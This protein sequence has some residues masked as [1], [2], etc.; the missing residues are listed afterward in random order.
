[1]SRRCS[2]PL[3]LMAVIFWVGGC[4]LLGGQ[5]PAPAPTIGEL[6]TGRITVA[7]LPTVEIAPLML[8]IEEGW[9]ADAGLDVQVQTAG[10]GPAT[11]A[12]I[13]GGDYDIAYSSYV[14]FIAAQAR[15]VA[16]L[17]IVT[18]N[19]F[20][21]PNTA[22]LVTGPNSALTSVLQLEGRRIA[23][24][25]P[26]TSA[27]L[28]VK[29]AMA[30]NNLDHTTVEWRPMPFPDMAAA[31]ERGDID[32]AMLVEPFITTAELSIGAVPLLDLSYGPT[33][34]L[35][36][37]GYGATAEFVG[38]H[39]N[40]VAVFQQVMRRA[41]EATHDD[42]ARVVKLLPKIVTVDQSTARL[43]NLPGFRSTLE[44]KRI[45]R[46][47]DLM[48]QFG[49]LDAPFDVAPML[50]RHPVAVPSSR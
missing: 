18:D 34:E 24:P 13:V 44:A 14:P 2:R 35:P 21:A 25:G 33:N 4:G 5:P 28:L 41:A 22:M 39:P 38:E 23:V 1:M 40:T 43:V 7:V 46:V 8:A 19:S 12:G 31:L 15:Q 26:N 6:E 32:A 3:A 16:D 29:S 49:V 20:A 10:S 47:A 11:I 50:L 9:F 36:F 27:D 30:V 45:Q 17:R 42:R 37:T 48:V